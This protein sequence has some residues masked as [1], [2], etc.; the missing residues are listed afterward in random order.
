M[1][2][3][4]WILQVIIHQLKKI[5]LGSLKKLHIC[6]YNSMIF[7]ISYTEYWRQREFSGSTRYYSSY[8]SYWHKFEVFMLIRKFW[9]C[10]WLFW[11]WS[12]G[13][14]TW[15]WI[16]WTWSENGSLFLPTELKSDVHFHRQ[17]SETPANLENFG[18]LLL[19]RVCC[20]CRRKWASDKDS[21]G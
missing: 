1:G 5:I 3:C 9:T 20:S 2:Q 18:F 16:F 4:I 13:F 12:Y 6:Y 10:S 14:W 15:S 8:F 17:R 7:L 11:T 19:S 21:A